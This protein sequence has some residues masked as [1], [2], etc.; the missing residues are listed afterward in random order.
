M[1]KIQ[2][3]LMNATPALKPKRTPPRLLQVANKKPVGMGLTRITLSGPELTGFPVESNG[4]HIKVFL[5]QPHQKIPR[6]PELTD[7]G[8]KWPSA[9]DKPITRTYSVRAFRP[10]K[11][12]LD[13]DF[14]NHSSDS[15]ASG[16]AVNA[17]KG[18]FL[19]IAGPGGPKPLIAP[20]QWYLFAGDLSALPAIAALIETL[21]ND[22]R[23]KALVEVDDVNNMIPLKRPDLLDIEWIVRKSGSEALLNRI[24]E[25]GIEVEVKSSAFIAGESRT[26][27]NIRDHLVTHYSFTKKNLYA[28]PYWRRG[29]DEESYHSD[30]HKIMDEVY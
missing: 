21:P 23:G 6:L 25:I 19:G 15:P 28:V 20:S 1:G 10:L 5:P 12:E 13:I 29:D 16:W 26:V 8:I 22:A 24:K 14:V 30:R 4:A 9:E 18:D 7:T 2:D 3:Q 27:V 11:N 17:K